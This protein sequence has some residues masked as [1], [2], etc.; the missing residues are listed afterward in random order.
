MQPHAA[1]ALRPGRC[2]RGG[3]VLCPVAEPST[4]VRW[5]HVRARG[6]GTPK[7]GILQAVSAG[8][9]APTLNADAG[10]VSVAGR[11]TSGS[12]P[13]SL[14]AVVGC[15]PGRGS[16]YQGILGR[17][18]SKPG[19]SPAALLWADLGYG[20][21][22]T[23]HTHAPGAGG[24]FSFPPCRVGALCTC[25]L[26]SF[27]WSWGLLPVVSAL[28]WGS[29]ALQG[30]RFPG[31]VLAQAAGSSPAPGLEAEPA[32]GTLQCGG[33]GTR[34]CSGWGHG[35]A[36]FVGLCREVDPWMLLEHRRLSSSRAA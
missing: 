27:S 14:G 5:D 2:G 6:S 23:L 28:H 3:A 10:S 1:R 18:M 31:H 26:A 11:E 17:G 12:L 30:C 35:S 9:A 24:G 34:V 7:V 22:F 36:S 15:S 20:S 29:P 13:C 4:R 16:R 21:R 8:A 33:F 25:G 32:P 19:C